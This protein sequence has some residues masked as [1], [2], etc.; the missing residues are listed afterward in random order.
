MYIVQTAFAPNYSR[1]NQMQE[2]KS[3]V[4]SVRYWRFVFPIVL[5]IVLVSS[6]FFIMSIPDTFLTNSS[7]AATAAL[8]RNIRNSNLN[9]V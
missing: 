1:V 7:A 8:R 6:L 3:K 2:S 5:L 4:S 9:L